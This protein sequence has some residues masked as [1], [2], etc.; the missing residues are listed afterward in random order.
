MKKWI[1]AVLCIAAGSAAAAPAPAQQTVRFY[2]YAYDLD[3]GKYIYTEVYREDIAAGRWVGGETRYYALDGRS[4]GEKT[5]SFAKDPYIPVYTLNLP[6]AGYSEGIADVAAGRVSMFKESRESGRKTGSVDW[7][8]PMAAD[9]GFHSFLYDHMPEL[10]SGRSI[11]FTFA[12]AG[13][14]DSYAFRA[15]KTGDTRFEGQPAVLL[16]VE[17]SSLLRYLVAPLL[18]T[19]DPVSRR[20]LEYRGISN[21]INPA[22][23]KAYNARIDYFSQPPP[24]AP[25]NLPPL[26]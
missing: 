7:H 4:L 16:K 17:P 2:G 14:L 26:D 3:T 9:S 24:D 12:A 19:Y 6:A 25:K 15:A 18:L 11:R 8:Q 22:T 5:L 23:G 1:V 10:L 20:L 13:Q 21:V